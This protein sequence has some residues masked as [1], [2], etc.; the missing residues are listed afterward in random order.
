MCGVDRNDDENVSGSGDGLVVK[1]GKFECLFLK[2]I[3][4][5]LILVFFSFLSCTAL[6][7]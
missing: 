6:E 7:K 1:R 4:K 3:G 2:P 5:C